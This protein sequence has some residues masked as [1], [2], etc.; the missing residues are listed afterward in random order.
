MKRIF[1]IFVLFIL[2]TGLLT[3]CAAQAPEPEPAAEAT[4][5]Q[6]NAL[7][8]KDEIIKLQQEIIKLRQRIFDDTKIKMENAQASLI[9]LVNARAKLADAQIKLAEFQ[10]RDDLVIRELQNLVQFYINARGQYLERLESGKGMG[11]ELYELEIAL[12]ETNILLSQL[13]LE[14]YPSGIQRQ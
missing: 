6:E 1:I 9:D 12:M 13:I 4:Q 8:Q 2:C 3:G 10:D 14:S 5:E 11:K 7:A